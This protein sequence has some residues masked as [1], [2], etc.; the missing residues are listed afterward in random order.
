VASCQYFNLYLMNV[1]MLTVTNPHYPA[2]LLHL[3]QVP[4]QLYI[5]GELT[6]LLARPRVAVVGSRSLSAY[7]RE[8]THKLTL[9]LAEHGVVIISG[10][11]LGVDSVAHIAALAAGGQTIAV[12]PGSV[13]TPYP[14]THRR[15]A[16]EILE[17]GGVLVSEYP[18]G[19]IP[20]KGNFLARNRIIAGLAD[21]IVVTEAAERSGSLNTARYGMELGRDVLAV[22]GNIYS[23]TSVGTN[24]LI[25][26]GASV[27]TRVED[28]LD[29]LGIAATAVTVGGVRA[30]PQVADTA[31]QAIIDLLAAGHTDG[32]LLLSQSNLDVTRYN[33]ALTML[34][35]SG[36]VRALGANHW[37][38]R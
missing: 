19:T 31:Q 35:I 8:A 3:P 24:N 18:A 17:K 20:Y 37:S 5:R 21:V 2:M 29:A 26:T 33:Q 38:L 12:L 15:L 11:A 9:A 25:K 22:P 13:E 14:G 23:P 7:G 30:V 27:A 34:E 10:L 32:E 1:N 4:Q 36:T 28:I 6:P 16:E